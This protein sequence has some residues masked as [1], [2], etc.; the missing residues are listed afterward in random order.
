M[1]DSNF[2][3]IDTD[4]H[5]RFPVYSASNFAEVAP[6]RLSIISWSLVGEPTERATRAL[7]RRLWPRA[8]WYSG[9]RYVFV[10][11]FACRP[12]HN[13]S[14]YVRLG[15][16]LLGVTAEDVTASYFEGTPHDD[17]HIRSRSL[18]GRMP[19]APRMVRE[20]AALRHR[21]VG[22]AGEVG[23]LENMVE[24]LQHGG[25]TI[26]VGRT[27]EQASRTITAAWMSHIA[28][29][30]SLVPL[31]ATL[32]RLG[33]RLDSH[34]EDSE[35]WI[36][37]PREV[38]WTQYADDHQRTL[39]GA[40]FLLHPF[41]EL[42]PQYAPWSAYA[43]ANALPTTPTLGSDTIE[44]HVRAFWG[45][46]GR[47]K[48]TFLRP[49]AIVVADAMATRERTKSLTMRALHATRRLLP[50]L[51][52]AHDVS[53]Q[54]LPYLR[55]AELDGSI[56][57]VELQ[58]LARQRSRECEEALHQSMPNRIDFANELSEDV[59]DP[60]TPGRGVSPGRVVGFVAKH[61]GEIEPGRKN[62][63]VVEAADA[64]IQPL[65]PLIQG[66]LARR[67][68]ELSHIAILAR[69]QGVPAVVGHTLAGTLKAGQRIM[70]DGRT[71][72]VETLDR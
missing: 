4:P 6:A 3:L 12:Y 58:G 2:P 33:G 26:A 30:A 64:D 55:Y 67:G 22:L 28:V 45:M 13:L 34:W 15:T 61:S 19:V 42:L 46:L 68:S 5:P 72:E 36:V 23:T 38:V 24:T 66:L 25:N 63:F 52:R 17:I 11:Y 43:R 29:T 39:G 51:A 62:I 37:R 20:I 32:R 70:L 1:R 56:M 65:L 35:G 57:Q 47:P 41:Y 69:E 59:E 21:A 53:E 14:A 49:L 10:A 54:L 31:Q 50:H 9:S 27:Y 44:E 8:K 16:Q 48:T 7:A 60:P 71:G 40:E 18:I